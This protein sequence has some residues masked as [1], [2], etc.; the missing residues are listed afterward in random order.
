MQ[1]DENAIYLL[2]ILDVFSKFGYNYLLGNK[3]ADT[4]LG[5]IHYIHTDNG[6]EFCNRLLEVLCESNDIKIIHGRPYH[7]QSKGAVES[8]NKELKDY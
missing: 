2:S 1:T 8:Y 5:H 6:K 3:R 4:V 7:P